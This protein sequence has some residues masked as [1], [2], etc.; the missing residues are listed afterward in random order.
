MESPQETCHGLLR[1]NLTTL[2]TLPGEAQ[3]V[4]QKAKK[5]ELEIR[6]RDLDSR[7]QL[8]YR[9]GQQFIWLLTGVVSGVLAYN[10]YM[11]RL[12]G[13]VFIW[14]SRNGHKHLPFL[15]IIEQYK[16]DNM[17]RRIRIFKEEFK[18]KED[19]FPIRI[20]YS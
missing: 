15:L 9:L 3:K 1:S 20:L 2:T 5:G 7:L 19:F 12:R 4:L 14:K 11:G 18:D 6:L 8:F 16:K 17:Q 13:I 10:A